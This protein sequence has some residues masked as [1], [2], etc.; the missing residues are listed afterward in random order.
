VLYH[1]IGVNGARFEQFCQSPQLFDQLAALNADLYI[2]S[3]GTNE[4]QNPYINPETFLAHCDTFRRMIR[5][6]SPRATLLFTTPPASYYKGK[7][8]NKSVQAVSK[9]I[10]G[11]CVKNN[12]PCWDLFRTTSGLQGALP[13]KK[14]GLLGHD[15][16]HFTT[17]GYQLQGLLLSDAL[18]RGYN[19]Y[20]KK[21]PWVAAKAPKVHAK[22]PNTGK[23]TTVTQ[24]KEELH[25]LPVSKMD[26]TTPP[27]NKQPA[28]QNKFPE[29]HKKSNI[30]VEYSGQ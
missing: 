11:Y 6:I 23:L 14:Y 3:L 25:K 5:K 26:T 22:T 17:A 27:Q 18:A 2:V 24:A 9:L 7:K 10:N 29:P 12:I 8:P 1:S 15:L 21:H 16:V 19:N 4:A 20:E 28:I 30:K 13:M